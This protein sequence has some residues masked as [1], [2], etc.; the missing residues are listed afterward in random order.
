MSMPDWPENNKPAI[1]AAP[2]L[3]QFNI[4]QNTGSNVGINYSQLGQQQFPQQ[5]PQPQPQQ[6]QQQPQPFQ[7][8]FSPAIN[9]LKRQ[10]ESPGGV[11]PKNTSSPRI[12]NVTP[13]QQQ[14]QPQQMPN[15]VIFP[16]QPNLQPQQGQQNFPPNQVR[17]QPQLG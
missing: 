16:N 14:Q 11:S 8:P 10:R 4:Q 5:Q 1:N 6:Q 2:H 3:A 17:P 7:S 9:G 12:R 13:A 15:H